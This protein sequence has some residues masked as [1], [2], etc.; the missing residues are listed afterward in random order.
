MILKLSLSSFHTVM[1]LEHVGLSFYEIYL[2]TLKLV[3]QS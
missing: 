2:V 3:A 1:V